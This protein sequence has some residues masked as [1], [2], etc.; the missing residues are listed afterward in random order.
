MRCSDCASR[1]ST[2][3]REIKQSIEPDIHRHVDKSA[4]IQKIANNPLLA[5]TEI[6][7]PRKEIRSHHCQI[8]RTVLS[9]E[10]AKH[11]TNLPDGTT[12]NQ[13]S[14][15]QT[16]GNTEQT[17]IR[18]TRSMAT[19]VGGTADRAEDGG[20]RGAAATEGHVG[21]SMVLDTVVTG[22][23]GSGGWQQQKHRSSYEGSCF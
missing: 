13:I 20:A 17:K 12:G 3:L 11:G 2:A 15:L 10:L 9:D 4:T 1:T 8:A 16:R 7:L 14:V 23:G 6:R 5:A 18:S 22:S 21:N 19:G